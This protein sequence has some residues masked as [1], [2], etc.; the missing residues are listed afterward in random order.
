MQGN[1]QANYSKLFYRDESHEGGNWNVTHCVLLFRLYSECWRATSTSLQIHEPQSLPGADPGIWCCSPHYWTITPWCLTTF[2]WF[3]LQAGFGREQEA[4]A[5]L[6]QLP[7][8]TDSSGTE[9]VINCL[10][11]WKGLHKC[12]LAG[13]EVKLGLPCI[14]LPA[15]YNWPIVFEQDGEA[16]NWLQHLDPMLN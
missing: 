2:L 14:L 4:P 11:I 12:C 6:W 7:G 10:W 16:T 5:L 13:F 1:L 8:P 15:G 3:F 9:D